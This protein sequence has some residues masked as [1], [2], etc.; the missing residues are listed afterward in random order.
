MKT[1]AKAFASVGSLLALVVAVTMFTAPPPQPARAQYASAQTWL[2]TAGGTANALAFTVHNVSSL[3]DLI[4]VPLKFIPASA[5]TGP[6]T[7][8]L[9]IDGGGS[10][11]PVVLD[12]PSSVGLA[13]LSNGELQSGLF[14]EITYDGT[15]FVITSS[16]DMTPIGH[17]VEFRGTVAP[18][19]TLVEDGSCYSQTQYAALFAVIGTTYNSGAPVACTAG[20]FA[21]PD[22]R[23]S[24]FAATDNQG[25]NGSAGRFTNASGCSGT[26]FANRCGA[27]SIQ[28]NAGNVP[29]IIGVNTNNPQYSVG[30]SGST[31]N[32]TTAI[33]DGSSTTG[34]GV[35]PFN[36]FNQSTT[37]ATVSASGVVTVGSST[38]AF[39]STNT[40][41]SAF[42]V[43]N[44]MTL[45]LRAIKY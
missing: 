5:S 34:G 26:V 11:G 18:V 9:N 10:L 28:I 13:G 19:G 17:S 45:G 37:S 3:N 32:I 22:S 14:A 42:G 4:G 23:G 20:N 24:L 8:T 31:G 15:R 30:V 35:F 16:V 2:G 27:S 40:S 21:V 33:Q 38:I 6:V 1:F 29:T 25:N 7:V 43:L 12:R 39:Q 36:L 44:P 41:G